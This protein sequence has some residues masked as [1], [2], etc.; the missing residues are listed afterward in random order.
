MSTHHDN[1]KSLVVLCVEDDP[2]IA[3]G[4]VDTFSYFVKKVFWAQNGKEGFALFQEIKPDIIFTDIIMGNG[5][6]LE[7]IKLIRSVDEKTPIVAI[8]SYQGLDGMIEL[9]DK[10]LTS[11]IRKPFLFEEV[12]QALI[13]ASQECDSLFYFSPVCYFDKNRRVI[14]HQE[15]EIKLSVLEYNFL[16]L[17]IASH[18]NVMTKEMIQEYVWK[19]KI[20]SDDA[21]KT[22]IKRLRTKVNVPLVKA[23]P[24]IGYRVSLS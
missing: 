17:L 6:G 12:Y 22:L 1:L 24:D 11:F 8:T 20:M 21:L 14:F 16:N 23:I 13:K 5:D 10:K 7:L 19:D 2:I 3:E 15:Q 9:M 18:Q 4:L